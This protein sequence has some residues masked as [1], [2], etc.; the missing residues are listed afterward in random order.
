MDW[1]IIALTSFLTLISPLNLIGDRLIADQIR[2]RV[3]QVEDLSVR[4][5]NAPSFQAVQGKIERVRIASRGLEII[6]QLR[7]AELQLETDPIDVRWQSLS[8]ANL[9]K[10]RQSL[11]QPLQGAIAVVVTEA[12][13]NQALADKGVK[14]QLETLLN[15]VIPE[16]APRFQI[17]AIQVDF[18]D[19]TVSDTPQEPRFALLLNLRQVLNPDEE[20]AALDI[21]IET[22]VQVDNGDRLTLIDPTVML[23]GRK[24]SSR[25]VNSIT[26]SF[27]NRLSLK[28]LEQRGITA[29]ILR[30]EVTDEQAELSLFASIQPS[31][32]P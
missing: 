13:L 31:P 3:H 5:D 9:S 21:A 4:V 17:D 11:R 26:G 29:R 2:S 20:P 28:R 16:D 8:G 24:I 27:V 15:R 12:D 32:S 10:L 25:V 7:I 14:T 1:L 30:Y 22:G 18:L 6:P 23:N 19:P